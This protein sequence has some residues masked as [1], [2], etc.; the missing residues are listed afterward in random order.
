MCIW[1]FILGLRLNFIGMGKKRWLI[2]C[3]EYIMCTKH[4][5]FLHMLSRETFRK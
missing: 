5:P 3:K 2:Y 4:R 1:Q